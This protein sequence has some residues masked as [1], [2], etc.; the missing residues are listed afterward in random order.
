MWRYARI[1]GG[2]EISRDYVAR[3]P[4]TG[5]PINV[6]GS[7]YQ[8]KIKAVEEGPWMA[9]RDSDILPLAKGD[10]LS[11]LVS[12]KDRDW[13]LGRK[14]GVRALARIKGSRRHEAHAILLGALEDESEVI[15]VAALE[16]LPEVAIQKSD[17]LFDWL[18]VLLDDSSLK[19]RQAASKC[20]AISTPVF[21]SA[22]ETILENELRH[23]VQSRSNEAWK[24]LNSLCDSWPEVACDHIDTL[25]LEESVHLRRKAS[26]L[27]RKVL[28]KGGS[29]SWDLISWS[30][31]DDDPQVRRNAAKTLPSLAH[32]EAKVATIFAERAMVDSDSKVR[33]SA[34]KAIQTLDKDNGRARDLVMAGTRSKDVAVRAACID[35]L[36]RLLGE[37]ILRVTA[38]ELLKVE[39][40][41][42]IMDNLKKM[43]F[44][45]SIEGTEAQ[46]NAF[47]APA[48]AVPK[49]EREIA[50]AQGKHVGLAPIEKPQEEKKPVL[51]KEEEVKAKL[52]SQAKDLA[53]MYR[54]VSQDE[55]MGYDDDFEP[56]FD[57]EDEF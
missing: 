13:N 9:I 3:D 46:K 1:T 22:V 47:L 52:E 15:R 29:A 16:A 42:S 48:P 43:I 57:D 33:L 49:L 45:A 18:S 41:K 56:D 21:P 8:P 38:T 54:S 28:R 12:W 55:M 36:P 26:D 14:H 30:L 39:T 7:T 2:L 27:L 40:E 17:E 11:L 19:V 50:E 53:P 31:N 34:I 44:D 5:R 23:S 32:N 10:L 24:G 37:E 25:L 20:L 35:L 51:T 6:G 4:R